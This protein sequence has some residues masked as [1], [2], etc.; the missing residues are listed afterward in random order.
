ML[1]IKWLKGCC[2]SAL[3]LALAG[4][5]VLAQTPATGSRSATPE[6]LAAIHVAAERLLHALDNLEW[7]AFRAYWASD[8][9]VFF[10]FADTPDRVAG[11]AAVEAR[12]RRFF[13]EARTRKAGPPYLQLQPRD[14]RVDRY[15]DVGIVTFTFSGLPE[16]KGQLARRTLVFVQ[17]GGTWKVVH[18][19]A[20]ALGQQQ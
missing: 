17:E 4:T 14:L 1:S 7:E 18:V 3:A 10:P 19:H 9:T 13:D 6:D 20:S 5:S 15:G 8:P 12:W 16:L 2:W 11:Q